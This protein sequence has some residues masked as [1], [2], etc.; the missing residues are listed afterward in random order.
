MVLASRRSH[1]GFSG[2]CMRPPGFGEVSS[3]GKENMHLSFATRKLSV[4]HCFEHGLHANNK[5]NLPGI[6]RQ[7]K[8]QMV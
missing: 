5:P 3:D 4:I 6:A 1:A 7:I 2:I 8:S